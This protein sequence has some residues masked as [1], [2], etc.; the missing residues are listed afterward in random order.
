MSTQTAASQLPQGVAPSGAKPDYVTP[1]GRD[2][3]LDLLRGFMVFIM[4]NNHATATGFFSLL[5][6][7][8]VFLTSAAEG[9]V[10]ISG[11]MTGLV[12]QRA[13]RRDGLRAG[14]KKM[15]ARALT[16]Y[17]L[18]V[19]L[20]LVFIVFARATSLQWADGIDVSDPADFVLRV[21]TLRQSFWWVDVT[22]LYTLLFLAVPVAFILFERRL[23]WL[24]AA[25]SGALYLA[26]QLA[27]GAIVFP[28]SISS[29]ETFPVATWQ[30]LF[31]GGLWL[32]ARPGRFAILGARPGRRALIV[33]TAGFVALLAVYAWTSGNLLA[34]AALEPAR[35]WLESLAFPRL[36]LG[37][38]R[39]LATGVTFAFLLVIVTWLWAPLRRLVGWLLLPL[40]Q[41]G[42]YA[43]VVSIPV[44]A[45]A[46]LISRVG[47]NSTLGLTLLALASVGVVLAAV[48][49]RVLMPTPATR[50]YWL[51]AP[52]VATVAVFGLLSREAAV[53]AAAAAAIQ[54]DHARIAQM[55]NADLQPGDRIW[56]VGLE[57]P[58]LAATYGR[59]A[60]LA[61]ALPDEPDTDA[62]V[63]ALLSRLTSGAQRVYTVYYGERQADPDSRYERWLASRA[64][65]TSE[66]WVGDLRLAAYAVNRALQPTDV[67][68][69]WPDGLALTSV[70]ADLSPVSAGQIIPLALTWT[71]V[72]KPQRDLKVFVHLV[73]PDGSLTAQSDGP[74]GAVGR[75]TTSWA[76]G[77]VVV[78]RRGLL[79]KPGTPPGPRQ[80]YVG[81]YDAASG[82]R[83]T[84]PSGDDRLLIGTVELR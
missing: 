79:I 11:L 13:I 49:L 15:F 19:T 57:P 44:C 56:F 66:E 76:A 7:N 34:G 8:G 24:A 4:V 22:R 53:A 23:A 74:P 61:Q 16:L 72:G 41:H 77:E 14:L 47:V 12:Y 60:A 51:A 68:G 67:S 65:K 21:L 52:A 5:T 55:A 73:A 69:A 75:L 30:L 82:K 40:G 31:F 63:D 83:L 58:N 32:G 62:E 78:G 33:T 3:R 46:I 54:Q 25:A 36:E 80:I 20:T 64:F 27:P 39:L 48:K 17:A 84:L 59:A 18:T 42:L 6:G 35:A 71:A 37:P 45:S 50:R 10:L 2:L 29:I 70:Q 43:F 81:L 9:F 38:L 26:Y 28:W 1:A